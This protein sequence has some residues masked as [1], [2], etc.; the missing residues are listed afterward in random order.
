VFCV[1]VTLRRARRWCH[2]FRS[3]AMNLYLVFLIILC[4]VACQRACRV[5]IPLYAIDLGA[6]QFWIGVLIALFSLFPM[7][8]ALYAGRLSDRFGPQRP[9]LFGSI[10]LVIGLLT[11]YVFPA[12]PALYASAALFG[13]SFVFYHVAAQNLVGA[14]SSK[15]EL[16]GNFNNYG[17]VMAAGGFVGPLGSGLSIDYAGYHSSFLYL[18]LLAAAAVVIQVTTKTLSN[19]GQP[20]AGHG[21]QPDKSHKAR[22][23]LSNVRLRRTLIVG[24]VA[25]T[26]ND[27]FQ[28]YM[29]IYGH[30]IGLSASRIGFVLSMVAVA[31]FVV[32]VLMPALVRQMGEDTLLASSL[33]VGGVTFLVF[34]LFKD[35]AVLSLIAFVLGLGLGCA[36]PLSMM[37]TYANSPQG[38]SGEALGLRTTLNNFIHVVV[39]I[40][41][42]SIGS[43]F[44]LAPVFWINALLLA[45]GSALSRSG[46]KS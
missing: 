34:P 41:F 29:P 1:A 7:L 14:L 2:H 24:A 11:P 25:Q 21:K 8:F 26:G 3:T 30:S 32:R 28:F 31:A 22:D 36:Q 37:M 45:G 6:P 17:L 23:F 5:I 18:A 40:V 42:G 27:L 43:A 4:N 19:A 38:R 44:G 33:I 10:G 15:E 9:M 13:L 35:A 20:G 39:P 46:R 16:T 12:L